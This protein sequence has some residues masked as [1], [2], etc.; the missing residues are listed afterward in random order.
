MTALSQH[1]TSVTGTES[2]VALPR[3][4][5]VG[6][7]GSESAFER[8]LANGEIRRVIEKGKEFFVFQSLQVDKAQGVQQQT[9]M[10]ATRALTDEAQLQGM[11][12]FYEGFNPQL[13]IAAADASI[14]V[15]ASAAPMSSRGVSVLFLLFLGLRDVIK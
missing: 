5:M 15:D 12:A 4:I 9:S 8:G 13:Q 10:G 11:T 6:K 2:L 7:C 3:C 14:V 1:F